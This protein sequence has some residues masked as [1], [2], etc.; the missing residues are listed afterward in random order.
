MSIGA[1]KQVEARARSAAPHD[2]SARIDEELAARHDEHVGHPQLSSILEHDL[3]DD[4]LN[5]TFFVAFTDEILNDHPD[6]EIGAVVVERDCAIRHAASDDPSALTMESL[7]ANFAFFAPRCDPAVAVS[8]AGKAGVGLRLRSDGTNCP[9][10]DVDELGRLLLL[11]EIEVTRPKRRR[12]PELERS[13][14][15]APQVHGKELCRNIDADRSVLLT[16]PQRRDDQLVELRD[17][18]IVFPEE[19]E[20]RL[21]NVAQGKHGDDEVERF[22]VLV[23]VADA[24]A[25]N[26]RRRHEAGLG[27]HTAGGSAR[28]S[29]QCLGAAARESDE[30]LFLTPKVAIEAAFA[31]LSLLRNFVHGGGTHLCASKDACCCVQDLLAALFFTRMSIQRGQITLPSRQLSEESG[32]NEAALG[33]RG[34]LAATV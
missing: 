25:R 20:Q 9:H 13:E 17:G 22:A 5:G 27:A 31:E 32:R 1:T 34:L 3:R 26:G 14:E 11:H 19:R 6:V 12:T 29:C 30:Q 7:S 23:R 18:S 15:R 8:E 2:H 24:G 10:D 16:A 33:V 21:G 28:V 4:P